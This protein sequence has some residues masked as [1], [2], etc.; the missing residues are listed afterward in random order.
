MTPVYHFT[1]KRN[2]HSIILCEGC[3]SDR[4]RLER[5]I[6]HHNVA[7]SG[8]K[9]RRSELAVDLAP[10]GRLNEYVPFYFGA[11]SP[12]LYAYAFGN[13]TGRREDQDDLVYLVTHAETVRDAGLAFVFTDGHPV[14]E[15][16]KFYNDLV[17]LS[18]VDLPLMSEKYWNDTNEDP[19]R[20]RRR[21]AEFLVRHFLPWPL[22][23]AVG[24]RTVRVAHEVDELTT[25]SN[26]RPEVLVRPDWYYTT[27][28]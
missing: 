9:R 7:Y 12:M 22:I 28:R 4:L 2:L 21:Q 13:V 10:G 16:R 18:Y 25:L 23:S 1:H 15:P 6:S 27:R 20:K 26:H 14:R 5:G 8:L 17:D 3:L 19:D 11:R 24:V